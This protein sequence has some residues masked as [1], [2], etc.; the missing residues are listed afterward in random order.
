MLL[1]FAGY[2]ITAVDE[3]ET[4]FFPR[5]TES[6]LREKPVPMTLISK[7]GCPKIAYL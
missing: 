1:F 6:H 7:P 2:L 5:L 4:G 3:W